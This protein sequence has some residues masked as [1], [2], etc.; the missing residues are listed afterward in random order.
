MRNFGQAQPQA[1]TPTRVLCW[2]YFQNLRQAVSQSGTRNS[3]FP[4]VLVFFVKSKV[5]YLNEKVQATCWRVI[6]VS[7]E[8][9]KQ[10][11]VLEKAKYN[12]FL[13]YSFSTLDINFHV[14]LQISTSYFSFKF[15]Q[16]SQISTSII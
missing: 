7:C 10:F 13:S 2:S 5:I 3:T 15:K 1:P 9:Q 4:Q 8:P 16:H 6:Y 11:D 14:Q 12:L